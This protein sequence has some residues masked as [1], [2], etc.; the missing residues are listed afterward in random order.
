[1]KKLNPYSLHSNRVF[2]SFWSLKAT[3]SGHTIFK[4]S[5]E[6]FLHTC[7][8]TPNLTNACMAIYCGGL[9]CIH[10]NWGF[11]VQ[12]WHQSFVTSTS[13]CLFLLSVRVV[14]GNRGN[15]L[16]DRVNKKFRA[17]GSGHLWDPPITMATRSKNNIYEGNNTESFKV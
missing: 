1:M 14:L 17:G 7:S 13:I 15:L 3:M 10:G 9:F 11:F 8:S 2:L 4:T 16:S 12:C 6:L 5:L